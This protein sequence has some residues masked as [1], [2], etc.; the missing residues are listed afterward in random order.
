MKA[1]KIFHFPSAE[2]VISMKQKSGVHDI[3]CNN[4]ELSHIGQTKR[5]LIKRIIKHRNYVKKQQLRKS[6]I[7]RH[8]GKQNHVFNFSDTKINHSA[9]NI[10]ELEF[11]ESLFI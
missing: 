9:C 7:A 6:T 4:C 3:S 2:S 1:I 8:L 10:K 11:L 5:S